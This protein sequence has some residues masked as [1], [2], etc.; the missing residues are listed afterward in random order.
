V[1][2]HL[3]S[4]CNIN[5][6]DNGWNKILKSYFSLALILLLTLG[7]LRGG[8]TSISKYVSINDI[9][10]LSYAMWQSMVAAIL[11]ISMGYIKTKRFPPIFTRPIFFV[12]CALVGVAIP[13]VVFFYVVQTLSA[14]TMAVLLTLVPLFTYVLVLTLQVERFDAVRVGGIAMGFSGALI[15]ATPSLTNGLNFNWTVI[16][17]MICPLGYAGMSVFIAR[18][19]VRH[20]HPFLLA[21][22]THLVA[23]LFLLPTAILTNEYLSIWKDPGLIES[24]VVVHGV[25][26]AVAYSLFFKIVELAGPVFYSFSTYIIAITGICWGWFIFGETHHYS[27]WL[28]VV[29]IL[30]GLTIVNLRRKEK[31]PVIGV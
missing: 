7:T 19:P 22:G 27:F 5:P 14:G 21:G 10:P 23:F 2:T 18:Y 15:I 16:I 3:W 9:P 24:L 20:S 4:R 28:A 26:A 13:N 12:T 1:I 31:T 25:I 6:H 30:G 8:A 17:A 11:L 29:L